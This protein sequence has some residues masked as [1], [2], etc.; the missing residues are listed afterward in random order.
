MS[1]AVT[2]TI[3]FQVVTDQL[4]KANDML[5]AMIQK[6]SQ[7]RTIPPPAQIK[8]ETDTTGLQAASSGFKSFQE[9]LT[10]LQE[11][12]G[13][14]ESGVAYFNEALQKLAQV[15]K[16]SPKYYDMSA[17]L[18]SFGMSKAEISSLRS[19]YIKSMADMARG[20]T[21]AANES[22]RAAAQIAR[23]QDPIFQNTGR[24]RELRAVIREYQMALGPT[25]Y[26]MQQLSMQAYW[27]GIGIMFVAMSYY[28]LSTVQDRV[29]AGIGS[30]A[31]SMRSLRDAQ[32]NLH[33]S[34]VEYGAGSE[35]AKNSAMDLID[36]QEAQ[37]RSTE[38]VRDM[39]IQEKMAWASFYLGAVPIGMNVL[40]LA[41][42]L[43]SM[44][45]G[46]QEAG[47]IQ[48]YKLA[49]SE[50]ISTG[51]KVEGAVT[52]GILGTA[53]ASLT[54]IEGEETGAKILNITITKA[55]T[56]ATTSYALAHTILVGVLTFGIGALLAVGSAMIVQAVITAQVNDQMA[57]AT[58]KADSFYSSADKLAGEIGNLDNIMSH[59]IITIRRANEDLGE[60]GKIIDE[61][62][63]A[64]QDL[65]KN[66]GPHSLRGSYLLL[67]E[68]LRNTNAELIKSS[69]VSLTPRLE[70]T[71]KRNIAEEYYPAKIPPHEDQE[72]Q[73]RELL[74]K[75][76]VEVPPDLVQSI[77]QRL[78]EV[79]IKTPENINQSILQSLKEANI[80]LVDDQKQNIFQSLLRANI[81]AT[82]SMIQ[83]INQRFLE[84]KIPETRDQT[85]IVN[86][87]LNGL[88]I[89]EVGSQVQNI[90]Q[91]LREVDIPV[92]HDQRQRITQS[93]S[94]VNVPIIRDQR[95]NI[96]QRLLG[97]RVPGVENT[98]Q[99]IL[100]KLIEAN[101]PRVM[102]TNQNIKQVLNPV[103]IEPLAPMEQ[104]I[105]QKLIGID[106][107]RLEP[108]VQNVTV[109]K[110]E[111]IQRRVQETTVGIRTAQ[112]GTPSPVY[113]TGGR[114]GM[115]IN[116]SFPNLTIREEADIPKIATEIDNIF[117][118]NYYSQG[119]RVY[120]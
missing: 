11:H 30:L 27:L 38:S 90:D 98:H 111:A 21:Q 51:A 28:R 41:L 104:E 18:E 71:E 99:N 89:L 83:N 39:L 61:T 2:L 40:R 82:P 116:V 118:R 31:R 87:V 112:G 33:Q 36:A 96:L 6:V 43:M 59:Y 73:I 57:Q 67:L 53:V 106:I 80:P 74:E 86:Q 94:S 50:G 102:D 93:L 109:R 19:E 45:H 66:L 63:G 9:N 64:S 20:T 107:P 13:L 120:A 52:T 34:I 35:E 42:T 85:Q 10:A 32:E 117:Q 25:G 75:A 101:I 46:F 58:E 14:T 47:E 44:Y 3:G 12:L 105:I 72:V 23:S 81:P 22:E 62:T 88:E 115:M 92:I 49:L 114:Q 110:Q 48:N 15:P 68:T 16:F 1:E 97:T 5:D 55:A 69:K 77:S 7:L 56:E 78:Y 108:S 37:R 26:F 113:I 84:T 24:W 29:D 95:Q 103:Q 79:P 70:V 91:N 100:Q 119:G 76:N 65:E 54:N 17:V 8:I 4:Q 60:S